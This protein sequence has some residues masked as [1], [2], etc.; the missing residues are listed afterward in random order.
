[1]GPSRRR[2]P[3]PI[4]SSVDRTPCFPAVVGKRLAAALLAVAIIVVMPDCSVRQ[5]VSGAGDGP[6]IAVL[7]SGE[8][9]EIIRDPPRQASGPTPVDRPAAADM[10][11]YRILSTGHQTIGSK[12]GEILI[13]T[14]SRTT[15]ARER[16]SVARR[17]SRL[18]GI[19]ELSIYSSE[20]AYRANTSGVPSKQRRDV[21]R[22]GFLG[23]IRSGAFTSGEDIVP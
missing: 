16:E 4:G 7:G 15:S 20:E 11:A 12:S 1:M 18:E 3:G 10:P 21:L 2:S 17:I 23:L 13:P 14:L 22:R 6:R 8:G 9:R 5:P 19:D